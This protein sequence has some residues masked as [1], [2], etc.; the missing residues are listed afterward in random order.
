MSDYHECFGCES[1]SR[2]LHQLETVVNVLHHELEQER[3]AHEKTKLYLIEEIEVFMR[4]QL[5]LQRG[6]RL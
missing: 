5:R 2:T 4:N 6:E 1:T 3:L